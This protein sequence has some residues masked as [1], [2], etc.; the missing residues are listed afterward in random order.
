MHRCLASLA[1]VLVACSSVGGFSYGQD[2]A[3][4]QVRGNPLGSVLGANLLQ[5]PLNVNVDAQT[6][7]RG[8]G[9]A[10]HVYL[11]DLTFRI[12]ATD[13]PMGDF[14]FLTSIAIY[15]QSTQ[16]GSSLPRVRVAHLDSVPAGTPQSIALTVDGV[17]LIGYVREGAQLTATAMGHAPAHDTSFDGHLDLA[18][19]VL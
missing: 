6:A 10:Q 17:D 9:P 12:T 8:T 3:E 14:S 15:V 5:I 16:S 11:T 1:L 18:I 2:I 4:Q 7:A 13:Q 19:D